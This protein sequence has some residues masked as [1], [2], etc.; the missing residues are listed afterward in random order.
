LAESYPEQLASK[1]ILH[2]IVAAFSTSCV[3]PMRKAI[4][5][6][7]VR[8]CRSTTYRREIYTT[9]GARADAASAFSQRS[10]ISNGDRMKSACSSRGS[11][12]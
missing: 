10:S 3:R 8:S 1:Y 11:F 9:Y 5:P 4:S 2:L 12:S 7:A 6:K